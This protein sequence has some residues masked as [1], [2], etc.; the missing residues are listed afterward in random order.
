MPEDPRAQP[1]GA[2]A[3]E[4]LKPTGYFPGKTF[5]FLPGS[6]TAPERWKFFGAA[7]LEMP[8]GKGIGVREANLSSG[9]SSVGWY[10]EKVK[11]SVSV[12]VCV[13]DCEFRCGENRQT[14]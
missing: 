12:D 5:A 14:D 9:K 8:L 13:S 6:P 2:A 4:P 11:F 7:E 1:L 3:P 10:L